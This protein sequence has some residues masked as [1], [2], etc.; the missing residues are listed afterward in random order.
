MK[1]SAYM[2]I[3]DW[4]KSVDVEIDSA[5][6]SDVRFAKSI[7]TLSSISEIKERPKT[8]CLDINGEELAKTVREAI[9]SAP[10]NDTE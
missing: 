4:S 7:L 6:E 1:A 9:D 5:S 3:G 10:G 8:V 2:S